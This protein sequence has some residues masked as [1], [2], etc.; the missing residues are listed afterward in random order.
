MSA[1]MATSK[2]C[3]MCNED[4]GLMH[5]TGCDK[6][7]CWRDF[8]SHRDGMF[9]EMDKIVEERN[10]LQDAINNAV[11][12]NDEQNPVIKEIEKWRNDTIKK[13]EKIAAQARQ[14]AIQLLNMKQKKINTEFKSFSQELAKLKESENFVEH[15][16][17]RLN[18]M[19]DQFK[20]D[21]RQLTQPTRIKLH[22]D[23]SNGINWN[24]LI[25]VEEEQK[26]GKLISFVQIRIVTGRFHPYIVLC[27]NIN[28]LES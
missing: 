8:R 14:Q 6:Y 17:R 25:Y 11:Q 9:T 24:R 18:Q 23:E 1:E 21:L 27:T 3:S 5:C 20:E 19:I 16:L 4:A 26:D 15:D 12:H 28:I 7:F 10:H 13:V 2:E 22:T